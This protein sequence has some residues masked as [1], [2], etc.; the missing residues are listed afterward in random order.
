MPKH[1][2]SERNLFSH[3]YPKSSIAEAFRTMRTNLSFA[4]TDQ[5]LKV[6][7]V[8]SA[9]PADGKTTIS[10][11]LAVV[12]AQAGMRV[13]LMDCDLRKPVLHK[14]F[15]TNNQHGVTNLLVQN[16]E[17]RDVV[18]DTPVEGLSL[19]VS[20]P[21]P[22]NPSEL[23]GSQKMKDILERAAGLYDMVIVDAPPVLAVTDA[24]VL[25]PQV[26]GVILVVKSGETRIDMI[27]D[28][29]SQLEKVNAHILGVVLNEVKI[30]S[31]DYHY[32]YYYRDKDHSSADS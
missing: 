29:K 18:R 16:L 19:L 14:Y 28:T 13:L 2:K 4:A 21:I 22:P 12:L 20:G 10:T 8:T 7:L 1:K 3:L 15:D 9:G 30:N 6:I 24:A 31:D 23:L 25:A 17:M 32:Y 26:D 11:N 5:P 27:K